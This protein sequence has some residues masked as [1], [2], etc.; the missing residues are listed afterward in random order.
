MA[1]TT[2]STS[3]S[4]SA[5]LDL[6]QL[7]PDEIDDILYLTRTNDTAEL[8]SYIQQVAENYALSPAWVLEACVDEYTG[9]TVL[10]YAAANGSSGM[11]SSSSL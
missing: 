5:P 8:L 6:S 4:T 2:P 10:H 11:L 1:T 3:T 9:N 7:T